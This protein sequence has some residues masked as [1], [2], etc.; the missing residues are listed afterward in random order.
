MTPH[1]VAVAAV[2][3]CA[4]W[5]AAAGSPGAASDIRV[6][7]PAYFSD[8]CVSCRPLCCAWPP[9]CAVRAQLPTGTPQKVVMQHVGAR[10][11]EARQR[12]QQQQQ[13]QGARKGV[14]AGTGSAGS[15]ATTLLQV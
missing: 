10:Y 4:H 12:H 11:A 2:H 5:L 15:A 8:P 3:M 9:S 14:Q 6:C 1:R 13:Q 7:M